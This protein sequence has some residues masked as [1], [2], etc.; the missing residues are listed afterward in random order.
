MAVSVTNEEFGSGSQIA[1]IQVATV[2]PTDTALVVGHC[3][4]MM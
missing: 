4:E 3:I 1:I 2:V